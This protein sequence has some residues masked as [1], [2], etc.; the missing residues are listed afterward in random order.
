MWPLSYDTYFDINSG[1]FSKIDKKLNF[2]LLASKRYKWGIWDKIWIYMYTF[3]N[4][5]YSSK[6]M[7]KKWSNSKI[8]VNLFIQTITNQHLNF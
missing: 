2:F 7:K 5:P 6:G 8:L 1:L 3:F 4:M